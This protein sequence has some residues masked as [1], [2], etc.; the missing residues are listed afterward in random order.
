MKFMLKTKGS[1]TEKKL[2]PK[3]LFVFPKA[4]RAHPTRKTSVSESVS[5]GFFHQ[6]TMFSH[7]F[8]KV[9][10]SLELVSTGVAKSIAGVSDQNHRK[11]KVLT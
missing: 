2:N 6:D 3:V 10:V 8:W 1:I 7:F 4:F 5:H 11:T 9:P